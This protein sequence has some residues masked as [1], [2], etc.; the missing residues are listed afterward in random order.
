VR[1]AGKAEAELAIATVAKKA[2]P[3]APKSVNRMVARQTVAK[4]LGTK[5][6]G[7]KERRCPEDRCQEG[8]GEKGRIQIDCREK[9]RFPKSHGEEKEALTYR[10]THLSG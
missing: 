7:C 8:R 3:P 4:K 5:K 9:G 10:P 2:K 6:G 1:A